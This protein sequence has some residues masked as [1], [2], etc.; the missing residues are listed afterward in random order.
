M[1]ALGHFRKLAPRDRNVRATLMNRH[2][3]ASQQVRKVP[4]AEAENPTELVPVKTNDGDGG[5]ADPGG[6][7]AFGQAGR[8]LQR[9]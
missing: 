8:R 9:R 1:S 4:E 5:Y 3:R 2:P 7:Q 6:D